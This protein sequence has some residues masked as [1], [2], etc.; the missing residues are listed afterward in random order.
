[1]M[2]KLHS[3]TFPRLSDALYRMLC[4]PAGNK[5][6]GSLPTCTMSGSTPELSVAVGGVHVTDVDVL[7]RSAFAIIFCEQFEKTGPTT[8]AKYDKLIFF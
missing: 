6:P 8:S 7:P 5:S 2:L 3:P 1:M 4:S